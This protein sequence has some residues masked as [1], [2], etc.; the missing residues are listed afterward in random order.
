VIGVVS[1]N[2]KIRELACW[3]CGG[4]SVEQTKVFGFGF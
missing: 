1:F 4:W 2:Y 3:P